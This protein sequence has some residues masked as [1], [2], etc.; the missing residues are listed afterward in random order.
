MGTQVMVCLRLGICWLSLSVKVIKIKC[1]NV[2]VCVQVCASHVARLLQFLK[3]FI[4]HRR[5]QNVWALSRSLWRA[6]ISLDRVYIGE[7]VFLRKRSS[8]ELESI[9]KRLPAQTLPPAARTHR[10]FQF[11][12]IVRANFLNL[13][14]HCRFFGRFCRPT[15]RRTEMF[16]H[17]RT[18]LLKKWECGHVLHQPCHVNRWGNGGHS[19]YS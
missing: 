19:T 17:R 15:A 7:C 14:F 6:E 1:Q 16:Y 4:Y 13:N 5:L 8:E 2:C 12:S 9:S 18:G 3:R 11:Y 10:P